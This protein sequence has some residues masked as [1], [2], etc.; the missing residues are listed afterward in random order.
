MFFE[1]SG[2][3]VF[4]YNSEIDMR[5]G[6]ER[7]H[8]YCVHQMNAVMDQGHVYLFFGKNRRRLKSFIF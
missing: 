8:S 3:R 1:R 2:L 5:C 4:V 7:L 6:F